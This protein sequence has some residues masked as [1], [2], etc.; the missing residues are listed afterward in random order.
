MMINKNNRSIVNIFGGPL[1]IF[2]VIMGKISF[3]IFVFSIIIFS[4]YEYFK[5]I[6]SKSEFTILNILLGF[7]WISSISWL[8]PIYQSL[9]YKFIS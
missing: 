5:L 2:S 7:F 4:F 6:K 8:I 9:S 3:L 1:I